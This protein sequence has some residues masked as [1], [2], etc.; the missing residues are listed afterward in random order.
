VNRVIKFRA[1]DKRWADEHS[2]YWLD[3]SERHMAVQGSPDIE[4]LGSFAH[5]YLWD[6]E[7]I[8]SG[9]LVIMQFTGLLDKNGTEIYEGDICRVT[10]S[11]A[12]VKYFTDLNWDSGGSMH[13]GFWF[14]F[15]YM[16][17]SE[18]TYH[19]GFDDCEVIGNIW[20][21]HNLLAK[22]A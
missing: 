7:A 8:A 6:D 19:D 21:H 13:P 10:G 11:I 20:E 16:R 17:Y 5:L 3:E 1:W 14:N 2:E 18:L 15:D 12:E 4:T 9:D 22:E